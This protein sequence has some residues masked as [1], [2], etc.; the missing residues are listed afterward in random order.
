MW[1]EREQRY[2]DHLT[3]QFNDLNISIHQKA[4]KN[5]SKPYQCISNQKAKF[6]FFIWPRG[7]LENIFKVKSLAHQKV[8]FMI[9]P[10]TSDIRVGDIRLHTSDIRMTYEWHTDDIRVTYGWYTST[11]GWHTDNIRVHTSDIRMTWNHQ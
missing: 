10:Q 3:P 6:I 1:E 2:T 11:Y 7:T 4:C 9:K 5:K 8:W